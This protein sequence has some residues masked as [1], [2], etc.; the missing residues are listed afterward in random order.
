MRAVGISQGPPRWYKGEVDKRL[1]PS[2]RMLKMGREDYDACFMQILAQ[3][4]PEALYRE[5]KG[6]TAVLLCWET[7]NVW[8]H[9]RAVAEWFEKALG[10]EV[11]ELGLK[12]S[13][14]LPYLQM[15]AKADAPKKKKE[16]KAD[17]PA[18]E[19]VVEQ[20]TFDLDF[21]GWGNPE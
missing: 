4:D 19:P 9:R 20:K 8:C 10:I 7:P 5:L 1:A 17:A 14:S 3:L 18:K 16:G 21:F 15:P 2:W 6:D 12:R 13:E 11:C